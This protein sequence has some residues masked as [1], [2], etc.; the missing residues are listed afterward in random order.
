[1]WRLEHAAYL[2]SG[3]AAYGIRAHAGR[4]LLY[5]VEY[6]LDRFMIKLPHYNPWPVLVIGRG[7]HTRKSTRK[8]FLLMHANITA[9][10]TIQPQH[11]ADVH[12]YYHLFCFARIEMD[13]R[14]R[15][16][17]LSS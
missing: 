9:F 8:Q 3:R 1:M 17:L 5:I 7:T 10:L 11:R 6:A 4:I 16:K 15:R 12:C 13:S 14:S 2:Y